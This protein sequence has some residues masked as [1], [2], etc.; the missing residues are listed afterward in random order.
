MT[1]TEFKN[2]LILAKRELI[3][4]REKETLKI[5]LDTTALIKLRIQNKGEDSEGNLFPDYTTPYKKVRQ[6]KS[7]QIEK[8]DFTDTGRMFA[9]IRPVLVRK[10]EDRIVYELKAG[11]ALNQA[12]LDGQF[13]KRGNIL[14]PSDSEIAQVQRLNRQRIINVVNRNL[15]L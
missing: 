3:D 11:N 8:V 12:K 10:D 6:K 2:R 1:L 13:K 15:N 5:L 4:N 14:A 7:L 9:N